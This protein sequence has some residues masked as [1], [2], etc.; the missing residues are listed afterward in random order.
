M[1]SMGE[2]SAER[3]DQENSRASSLLKLILMMRKRFSC[4]VP[5]ACSYHY[6]ICRIRMTISKASRPCVFSRPPESHPS[7]MTVPAEAVLV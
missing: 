7:I 6:T 4:R 5:D 3:V 1:F 2:R